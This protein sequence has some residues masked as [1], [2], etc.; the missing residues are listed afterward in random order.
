MRPKKNNNDLLLGGNQ[1]AVLQTVFRLKEDAY[2][3]EIYAT[4]AEGG[5]HLHLPRIYTALGQLERKGLV[6]H[7]IIK[8]DDYTTGRTTKVYSMTTKGMRVLNLSLKEKPRLGK[9]QTW[10]IPGLGG[11]TRVFDLLKGS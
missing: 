5:E 6:V 9:G 7:E 8:P 4:L 11:I 2:A 1:L 3:G 10:V